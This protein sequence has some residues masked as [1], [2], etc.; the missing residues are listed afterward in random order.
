MSNDFGTCAR[1]HCS[2]YILI[3]RRRS[4]VLLMRSGITQSSMEC[5]FEGSTMLKSVLGMTQS[6]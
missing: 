3:L 1:V 5:N 4:L 6:K 2:L